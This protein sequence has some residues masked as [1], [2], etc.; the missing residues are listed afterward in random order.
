MMKATIISAFPG[1][2]KT[3]LFDNDPLLNILDSDSSSYSWIIQNGEK[4]RNPDFPANYIQHIK[5]E[6]DKVDLILVSSHLDVREALVKEGIKFILAYPKIELKDEYVKRFIDRGSPESFCDL[7]VE[8]WEKWI[9][10]LQ[11]QT[12][13][14]HRVLNSEEYLTDI[15]MPSETTP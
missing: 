1:T 2:G 14:T 8:N 12:S 13:C 5:E 10:E 7:V 15:F 4:K 3:Y 6:M 9:T 11:N